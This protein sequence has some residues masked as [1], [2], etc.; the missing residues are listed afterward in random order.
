[1]ATFLAGPDADGMRLDVAIARDPSFGRSRS[2]ARKLID[3][4]LVFVNGRVAK[5]SQA[6]KA[7]DS[8][9]YSVPP[10]IPIEALPEQISLDI[11]Y[12]DGDIVVINKERGMVVH[13]AAGNLTGTLV[14]A[15]LAH[16]KDI[17]VIGDKIR[18]GIVHR[19][20]KDTTGLLVVAKNERALH[21]LQ[22]QIKSKRARRTYLALVIGNPPDE[23]DI[24]APVGRDPHN[25]K[26]M[27]V[28]P[29]G[30]S[31]QTH[32]LVI[33]RFPNLALLMVTLGTGR[34]H[35]IRVHMAHIGFPVYG[36]TVYGPHRPS[37]ELPAQALHAVELAVD[38]PATG[39]RM[40]FQAEPPDDFARLLRGLGS[41][42]TWG[43][44]P[45]G[46]RDGQA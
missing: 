34:T 43:R 20:D 45:G 13:P 2:F 40:V 42:K 6:L 30:R 11:V 14:N 25:R 16:C 18:P 26:K 39:E 9:E 44:S 17:G 28:V 15:L 41:T 21:G 1:M 19:L 8:V 29:S 23:G 24:D 22:A 46:S 35:Q 27:A 7:G 36:D 38:H 5:P 12:E 32:F 37:K 3:D 4:G 10:A 31:A 33:E